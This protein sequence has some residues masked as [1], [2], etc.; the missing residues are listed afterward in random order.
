M[1]HLIGPDR[2]DPDRPDPE[3]LDPAGLRDAW[4]DLVHGGRCVVCARPGRPLCPACTAS[5]P[6]TGVPV[7]PHPCPPGLAP[8]RAAGPYA[9]PLRA[10]LLAHKEH[11]VWALA[12]PLGTVLASVLASM[13]APMPEPEPVP[14]PGSEPV[15]EPMRGR[16]A[17]SDPP[18]PVVLVP[19]PSRRATVRRRGHDPLTRVVRAAAG[20]LRADGVPALVVPALRLRRQVADQAGLAS[21]ERAANLMAAMAVTA[22]GR[23]LLARTPATGAVPGVIVCDDVLTT[24]AT[25]REA[26]RALEDAGVP[27][28]AIACIA[29]TRRRGPVTPPPSLPVWRAA[30]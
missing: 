12:G 15:P 30:H 13:L 21:G 28:G 22:S 27:V 11:G 16:S 7:A 18:G 1:R 17:R 29:A 6:R 9:D 14:E 23:S 8:C 26:Q 20:R 3:R 2:P 24:G 19:V 25:A 5:L 4:A 10:V